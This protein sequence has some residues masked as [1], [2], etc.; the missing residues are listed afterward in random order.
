MLPGCISFG[1]TIQEATQSARQA[2]ELH[3]ENLAAHHEPL[4]EDNEAA[5]IFTTVVQVSRTHV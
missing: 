4:P 2:I 5:P 1:I 3:L